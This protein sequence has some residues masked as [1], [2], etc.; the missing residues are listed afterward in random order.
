MGW[1]GPLTVND[2]VE[3]FWI[4]SIGFFQFCLPTNAW[5]EFNL[6]VSDY[7]ASNAKNTSPFIDLYRMQDKLR[8]ITGTACLSQTYHFKDTDYRSDGYGRVDNFH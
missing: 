2:F 7:T 6:F 8:V 1:T 5:L 3:I 4:P